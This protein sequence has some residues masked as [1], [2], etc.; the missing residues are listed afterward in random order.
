V[1]LLNQQVSCVV[2]EQSGKLKAAF[3]AAC[4][5]MRTETK[6]QRTLAF[7]TWPMP[8]AASLAQLCCW[9]VLQAAASWAPLCILLRTLTE[10]H[11]AHLLLPVC[12]YADGNKVAMNV[13]FYYM[14]N[15]MG[16]LTGTLV[17]GALEAVAS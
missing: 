2:A 11:A 1:Q 9:K 10:T 12:R 14:A 4:A 13:G 6:L 8:W 16:R 3:D 17:S 5:G 15:A 7:V